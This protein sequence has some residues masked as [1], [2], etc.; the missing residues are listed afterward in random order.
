[1]GDKLIQVEKKEKENICPSKS[2]KLF[3]SS[4][5]H[6]SQASEKKSICQDIVMK[7]KMM[8]HPFDSL[9]A[10]G[11]VGDLDSTLNCIKRRLSK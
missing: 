6:L 2:G 10:R 7:W 4:E 8:N 9:E 1:M 11:G 3:T 5:T